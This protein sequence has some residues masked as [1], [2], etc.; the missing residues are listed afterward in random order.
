MGQLLQ[1]N[2]TYK[3]AKSG[4]DPVILTRGQGIRRLPSGQTSF[5]VGETAEFAADALLQVEQEMLVDVEDGTVVPA[6]DLQ[7]AKAG[8]TAA[9]RRIIAGATTTGSAPTTSTDGHDCTGRKTALIRVQA[10]GSGSVVVTPYTWDPVSETWAPQATISLTAASS[11]GAFAEGQLRVLG[12][13]RLALVVT[14]NAASATVDAW[15]GLT[16]ESLG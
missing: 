7:T 13:T 4:A 6:S 11:P 16:Q 3:V 14:T 8:A 9:D 10:V 12:R 5:A 2:V 1:P 15:A